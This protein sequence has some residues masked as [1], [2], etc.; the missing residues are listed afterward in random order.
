MLTTVSY[1]LW[2]P[3][4]TTRISSH[5]LGKCSISGLHPQLQPSFFLFP[6]YR[7]FHFEYSNNLNRS[8]YQLSCLYHQLDSF[9]PPM[10]FKLFKL[11]GL[12]RPP[13]HVCHWVF[14]TPQLSY[15]LGSHPCWPSLTSRCSYF[16]IKF[17]FHLDLI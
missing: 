7:E 17:Y 15:A 5:M 6:S 8:H 12:P 9:S 4:P 10:I 2:S 3:P 14:F 13:I 16:H 11:S 1:V